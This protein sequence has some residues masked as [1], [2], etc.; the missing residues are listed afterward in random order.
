MTFGEK[1]FKLRKEHGFS[2]EMLAEQLHTTRQAISKW[3]NGQGYPETEKLLMMGHL[4]GVSIDYLLKETENIPQDKDEG[5]YVSKEMAEGY[6]MNRHKFGK[7][8]AAGL[9]MLALAC[10]PYFFFNQN[11]S[12]YAIP[13]LIIAVIGAGIIASAYTFE[14]DQYKVLTQEPL[15]FDEQYLQLLKK[16]Y[17]HVKKKYMFFMSLGS[18]LFF[19]G[20][21]PIIF[22]QKELTNGFYVPYYAICIIFIGIGI[23]ILTRVGTIL[24]AYKLLANNEEHTNQLFFKVKRKIRKKIEEF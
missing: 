24:D 13:T 23:Y 11:P 8:M 6:L 2:Q 5:F 9:F 20:F 10:I 18:I 22:E 15:L 1:L 16:R 14:E 4:F 3:E 19:I 21:L 17:K 7:Y 12:A